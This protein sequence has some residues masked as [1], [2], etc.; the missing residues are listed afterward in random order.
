M[1]GTGQGPVIR[2]S[3]NKTW[4][5]GN[6]W[7]NYFYYT[8]QDRR[9]LLAIAAIIVISLATVI[10]LRSCPR[11]NGAGRHDP[12][13]A[14]YQQ[15]KEE[16]RRND[17]IMRARRHK[18]RWQPRAR[19]DWHVA[20]APPS[21]FDPNSDDSAMLVN[22]G[23]TPYVARNIVRYRAYGGRFRK[24]EDLS[25]IYGMDSAMFAKL[26][27]Y[28]IIDLPQPV[29]TARPFV[30]KYKPIEKYPEGTV[31]DINEADTTALMKIPGIGRGYSRMITAYRDQ[32]GGFVSPSQVDEVENLPKGFAKWFTVAPDFTPRKIN[33]NRASIERLRAHPYLNFYKARAIIEYR[34][35]YG[36]LRSLQQLKMLEEFDDGTLDKIAPYIEF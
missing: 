3:Q 21:P 1:I 12:T 23:F 15:F 29:D 14:R 26:R 27:P 34:K 18:P 13:L 30:P 6:L 17:S 32:L 24:V 25:K 9:G 20:I 33:I 2:F 19:Q 28:A 11:D 35:K 5:M 8:K 31:I 10:L 7:R 22:S 36:D 16:L 4:H